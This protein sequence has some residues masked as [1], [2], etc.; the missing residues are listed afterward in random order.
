[1]RLWRVF[2][3]VSL[4]GVLLAILMLLVSLLFGDDVAAG[5][6]FYFVEEWIILSAVVGFVL[7]AAVGA[8]LTVMRLF[9]RASGPS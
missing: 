5:G 8:R 9:S 1:V 2:A 4:C 3:I 7:L 6:W